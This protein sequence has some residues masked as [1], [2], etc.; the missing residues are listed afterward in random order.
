MG[1]AF[2]SEHAKI[3][4]RLNVPLRLCLDGD[5]AGQH[6][7]LLMTKILD[8]YHISYQIVDYHG[9]KRD[10]DDIF[11]QDGKE[12]FITLV[13]KLI[14][15]NDFLI[16]Y[17]TNRHDLSSI[18]GKKDFLDDVIKNY[19]SFSDDIEKKLFLSQ[20]SS[21]VNLDISSLKELFKDKKVDEAFAFGDFRIKKQRLT[22]IENSEQHLIRYMLQSM[23]AVE[24]IKE[25]S[26]PVFI[27][28]IYNLLAKYIIEYKSEKPDIDI[29]DLINLIQ[30]TGGDQ[31]MINLLISI[32]EMKDMS[33]YS[34]K[35]ADEYID[36]I[37]KNLS[38]KEFL[39]QFEDAGKK[40]D[41]LLQAKLLDMR[42]KKKRQ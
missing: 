12:K 38:D 36:V 28:D 1:T 2:T 21:L 17:F 25:S 13:S 29:K 32:S 39:N 9:D 30:Q 14:K 42:I 3:L 23:E 35:S 8:E 4:R 40:Q 27:D 16:N 41:P 6:G 7:I 34:R 31:K 18:D 5:D 11:N 20:V 22:K 24:Y 26:V 19:S 15:K 37:Q 10:P 33:P